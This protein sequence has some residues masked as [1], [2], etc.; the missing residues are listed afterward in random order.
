M[1]KLLC[2]HRWCLVSREVTRPSMTG[3]EPVI[4]DGMV[5]GRCG[6][7]KEIRRGR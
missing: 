7:R 1:R 2:R 4:R 5:C 6:K 3:G